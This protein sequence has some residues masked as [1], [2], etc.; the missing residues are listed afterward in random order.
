MNSIF[1]Y[2]DRGPFGRSSYR[3][4][5]SGY[6]VRDLIAHYT[7]PQ[8]DVL[9]LDPMEGGGTSR[10]VCKTLNT[11]GRKIDY[12]GLDLNSGFN[13][14]ADELRNQVTRPVDFCFLHPPYH[15]MVQYSGTVWGTQQLTDDL[16]HCS[17]YPDFL[18]KLQLSLQNAYRA[19]RP[20]AHY[21][22]LIGDLRRRNT[23]FHIS[24]DIRQ[25][26][27]GELADV[28]I[29]EQHNCVSDKTT[30]SQQNF[31]RI[32]H[33]Y[34]LVFRK[35]NQATDTPLD[36]TLETSARLHTLSNSNWTTLTTA[37]LQQLDGRATFDQIC[38][39]IERTPSNEKR[40]NWKTKVLGNLNLIAVPDNNDIWKLKTL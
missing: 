3:G 21:A 19:L 38:A 25:L 16:S 17:S 26:A 33:E 24:A 6:V 11:Q 23:Y 30:Y 5:C 20:G 37:T 29:K 36:A 28:I 18:S 14:L 39:L 34:I 32:A 22:V 2:P 1:S 31:V 9:V 7:N 4:N 35:P 40:P 12:V 10:D 13:I 15:N 27:P 8:H